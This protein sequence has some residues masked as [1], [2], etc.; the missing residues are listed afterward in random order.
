MA[1]FKTTIDGLSRALLILCLLVTLYIGVIT[2]EV[3]GSTD[4]LPASRT[5][6]NWYKTYDNNNGTH[7][8]DNKVNTGGN[9]HMVE[10][11]DGVVVV[12][13]NYIPS[14]LK[15][16]RDRDKDVPYE[17]PPGIGTPTSNSN[18]EDSQRHEIEKITTIEGQI[19]TGVERVTGAPVGQVGAYQP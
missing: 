7:I 19:P 4:S 17:P 6:T 3:Q 14:V 9:Y 15:F 18:K 16:L 13:G 8:E 1:K 2:I 11:T 10:D 5:M 12:S